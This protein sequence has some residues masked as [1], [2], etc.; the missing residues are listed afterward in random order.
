VTILHTYTSTYNDLYMITFYVR[1]WMQYAQKIFVYDDDSTDGTR[2]YLE[3]M[4][5]LVEIKSPGFHGIDEILLQ[6]MRNRE[7]KINSRGI[8]DWCVIGD[9]DEFHYH[10]NMLEALSLKKAEGC[11]AVVSHGYQMFAKEAPDPYI[12]AQ[13][14][15]VVKTGIAD[16]I[17]DR[18]IFNPEIDISIGI[19]HHGFTIDKVNYREFQ[20]AGQLIPTSTEEHQR[21][22]SVNQTDQNF[23]MLHYKYLSRE[24]VVARH[25]RVNS[26]MSARN[27]EKGWGAHTSPDWHEYYSVDWYD[28]K[29]GEAKPC[30]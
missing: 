20:R 11:I 7:Y 21:R 19:G 26:R 24:H 17:Y 28:K 12:H 30:L 23:K 15:D 16:H 10:P 5:P 27:F 9:S 6:E 22:F 4:A 2:E 18:V 29:I 25:A 3:S 8:A 1:H 13:M 14:T